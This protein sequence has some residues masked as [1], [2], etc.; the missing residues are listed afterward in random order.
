M[1]KNSGLGQLAEV[2]GPAADSYPVKR[3]REVRRL[4][5][6]WTGIAWLEAQAV[7]DTEILFRYDDI[8][9]SST[10]PAERI[11]TRARGWGRAR[12]NGSHP[13]PMFQ[14]LQ[15]GTGSAMLISRDSCPDCDDWSRTAV[16][17]VHPDDGTE[18]LER[19]RQREVT[20]DVVAYTDTRPFVDVGTARF[21]FGELL[22]D[23]L[24]V[25]SEVVEGVS[26]LRIEV[27]GG[28][29]DP[30]FWGISPAGDDPF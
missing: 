6:N 8:W 18:G 16:C 3:K 30:R 15:L 27:E 2:A 26:S 10:L 24:E 1:I 17:E 29:G 14:V 13:R 5:P 19:A 9:E 28:I 4:N 21:T 20:R 12:G 22:D 23:S 7:H 11:I 25:S